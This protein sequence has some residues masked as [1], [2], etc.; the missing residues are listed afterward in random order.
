MDIREKAVMA[1]QMEKLCAT[2][3]KEWKEDIASRGVRRI[4]TK[5]IPFTSARLN[6]CLYGG[7]PRNCLI[8]FAGEEGSG[9]TTTSLD[10]CKQAQKLFME[11]WQTEVDTTQDATR[12]KYLE[13]RGPKK[14]LYVDCENTL[15]EDWARLLGVDVDDMFIIK[16]QTQAAEVIF[17]M[18]KDAILTDEIGLVILD[19]L[20]VMISQQAFDKDLTEKTF[21]GI[22]APLTLFSKEAVMLCR[23]Y[24]CTL[25]G[26]NQLR[27]DMSGFGRKVTTGG[28]GWKHNCSVR[29]FF[30]KGDFV[31]EAGNRV[32]KSFDSPAGNK[33][34]FSIAKTKVCKPDRKTGMYTLMYDYGIDEIIDLVEVAIKLGVIIKSGAWFTFC[35]IDTGEIITDEEGKEIKIQ[36]QAN[37]NQYLYDNEDLYDEIVSIVNSKL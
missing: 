13:A 28:R 29:I 12:K 5:K 23:K 9:K 1:S 10:V 18:I 30:D 8:E 34:V 16:P 32:N 11:E 19:S 27:D 3:N 4:E 6:Y 26:I 33:V 37:V 31:D 25:I 2:I 15:D 7:L 36:G 14:I 20:G 24:D 17:Q 22:S 35:D 21:G